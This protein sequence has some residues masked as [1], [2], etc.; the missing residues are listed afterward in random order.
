MEHLRNHGAGTASRCRAQRSKDR[1]RA[2]QQ[3]PERP[4]RAAIR[5]GRGQVPQGADQAAVELL[6]CI[7]VLQRRCENGG[8]LPLPLGEGWGEGFVLSLG[9]NPHPALRADLFP[10]ETIRFTHFKNRLFFNGLA[11]HPLWPSSIAAIEAS[12]SDDSHFSS[13]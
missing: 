12:D 2:G 9:L 6:D 8:A 5:G 11:G 4:V 3:T 10:W 1:R 7:E 13:R